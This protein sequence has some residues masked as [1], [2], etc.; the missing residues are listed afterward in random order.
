MRKEYYAP[1]VRQVGLW[2]LEHVMETSNQGV[3]V[4]PGTDVGWEINQD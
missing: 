2:C 1:Q 3:E 4:Q